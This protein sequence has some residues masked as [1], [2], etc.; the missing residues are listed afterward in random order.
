MYSVL[1]GNCGIHFPM[2]VCRRQHAQTFCIFK[3]ILDFHS[4]VSV[5]FLF[6]LLCLKHDHHQSIVKPEKQRPRFFPPPKRWH[7]ELKD[8]GS[9]V[10]V[11]LQFCV[12]PWHD[13]AYLPKLPAPMK[14]TAHRVKSCVSLIGKLSPETNHSMRDNWQVVKEKFLLLWFSNNRFLFNK[15]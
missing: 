3:I 1:P 5:R 7:D 11:F 8:S 10:A 14:A 12:Q 9:D 2:V 15:H 6:S 13:R 4:I